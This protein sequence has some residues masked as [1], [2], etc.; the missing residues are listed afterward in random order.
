MNFWDLWSPRAAMNLW[1]FWG[2][3]VAIA[4]LV[5]YVAYLDRCLRRVGE[6]LEE[7]EH[8]SK[9]NRDLAYHSAERISGIEKDQEL[10]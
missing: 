5:L 6:R 2:P 1:D 8:E 7:V 4:G 10:P 9:A 3:R